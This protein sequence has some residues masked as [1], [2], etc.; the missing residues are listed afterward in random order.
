[1]SE[2]V[3]DEALAAWSLG[4]VSADERE[5]AIE[6]AAS[7]D[8]CRAV[9]AHVVSTAAAAAPMRLGRYELRGPIGSGGM[10]VVL[11]GHDPAL[12]REVAIKM[13][14]AA[15][16]E[17]E[18]RERMLREAQAMAKV[19]HPNVV[20]VHELG[21][22]GDEVFVA[23]ELVTGLPLHRWLASPR[24]RAERIAV[25][26]GV[27]QG[28]AAVHAAGLLH[29]DIKPDNV[30]VRDDGTAVLVDFGLARESRAPAIGAGSGAAG[31]PR[32]LAPEVVAGGVATAASDQYQWWTIADEALGGAPRA[33]AR[34]IARGRDP[35]PA[36]RFPTM[37]AALAAFDRGVVRRKRIAIAAGALAVAAGAV[38]VIASVVPSE[39]A[40]A[41]DAGAPRGWTAA[42]RAGV[43]AQVAGAG[44]DPARVLAALDARV[45]TTIA[46]HER[47]CREGPRGARER[48]EW[49]RR[50]AC[51]DEA[52]ARV[53]QALVKVEAAGPEARREGVDEL[54]E[55]LPA[56]RCAAGSLLAVPA[57]L[58]PPE[59]ARY[60]ALVDRLHAIE[61]SA[62]TPPAQRL[63]ELRALEPEVTA[64]AYP[65][66]AARWHWSLGHALSDGVDDAAA[67]RELD[68]AAQTGLAAGDDDLYVRALVAELQ[69]STTA[70]SADR[71][72]QLEAAAAAGAAR[73][74][75][76][77]LDAQL[78]LARANVRL[79][80]G[81]S[82][83][84]RELF[85]AAD[86][87][88]AEVALAASPMQV[89]IA[90]NLGAIALEAGDLAAAERHLDRAVELAKARYTEASAPYWEARGA[91]ATAY[92][93]RGELDRAEPELRAVVDGMDR[94]RPASDQVV[95][96]R[97]YLCALAFVRATDDLGPA[98]GECAA[99]VAAAVA[100]SGADG[101]ANVW[102]LTLSGQVELKAGDAR[103]AV[104]F[105][106]RAVAIAAAAH[107]RPI[108]ATVA[109]TYRA[110]ALAA[111]GRRREARALAVEL[112][113]A[114]AGAEVAQ[115]RADLARA[116]P[117]VPGL[118]PATLPAP[119][120]GP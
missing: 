86:A 84:A 106:D 49:T 82:A 75:N 32:Y 71:V 6:H 14:N 25:V 62:A 29:R 60:E 64:L 41:C 116:F 68:L 108:E 57:R 19:A 77:Q 56:E 36:R 55:V 110:I 69:V 94:H 72:A 44:V 74:G 21:E 24:T 3:A 101:G 96:M 30:V 35:D 13:I 80:R 45:V 85:T 105:L 91:R 88:Y 107:V 43:E 109:R 78:L 23:M 47:A 34:A 112:A 81:E 54:A 100:V 33:V 15:L 103:A 66:L 20:T 26:R 90:Q 76:P 5:R 17:P 52:W 39:E 48:T 99:A 53:E 114:L 104:A 46:L 120:P 22:A 1:V 113:P 59:H 65:P 117:D 18:H 2:H 63:A 87:R 92:L 4:L 79:M 83:E 98:R 37:L 42:R 58:P 119:V 50:L 115:A 118:S 40:A 93:A 111:A 61:G 70:A 38:V 8:R 67:A 28:I 27:G 95:M 11:R 16:V 12:G 10:G 31:T 7:C 102:P 97:A 73:L 51:L 89:M 9:I